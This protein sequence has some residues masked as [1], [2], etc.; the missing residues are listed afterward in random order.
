MLP[1]VVRLRYDELT[2]SAPF[3]TTGT[4]LDPFERR[5]NC[6]IGR[7][8]IP[9]DTYFRGEGH[10]PAAI[11]QAGTGGKMSDQHRARMPGARTGGRAYASAVGL[12]NPVVQRTSA[13]CTTLHRRPHVSQLLHLSRAPWRAAPL[14]PVG[15]SVMA[16]NVPKRQQHS[17]ITDHGPVSDNL[18]RRDGVRANAK[19]QAVLAPPGRTWSP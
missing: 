12:D 18:T 15:R 19:R 14:P 2:P 5:F 1:E 4:F 7:P 6:P 8:T 16:G 17:L 11:N 13:R 9:I 10:K 3:S